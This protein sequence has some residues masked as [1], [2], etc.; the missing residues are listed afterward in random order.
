MIVT[1]YGL[2]FRRDG[3]R[4]R[5]VQHP[6]LLMLGGVGLFALAGDE[7]RTFSDVQEAL[8]CLKRRRAMG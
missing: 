3:D 2:L 8:A 1:E 7:D 5:C 4:W 6:E